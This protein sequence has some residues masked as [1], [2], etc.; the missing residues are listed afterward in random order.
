MFNRQMLYDA[1]IELLAKEGDYKGAFE[2]AE[3]AKSRVLID[4]LAG[5]DIGKTSVESEFIRQDNKYIGEIA[6]GYRKL[7]AA[8][9]GGTLVLKKALDKIEKAEAGHRD[10]ILKIKGQNEELYSLVSVEPLDVTDISQLLDKNTTLFSYYVTDKVLYIWAVNKDRV[11]L[12]RIKI[13]KDETTKLVSAF[14]A[15]ITAKDKKQTDVLSEKIYDNFLKPLIP[16]VKGDRI[17]FIPHGPLYYLP[18]A[19]MSY[20]GQY[21]VD[22]FSIFYLPGAGVLKYV[23]KKQPSAGL[24]VLAFGNPDLGNKQLDLPY[25]EAEVENIKN[26][27][28]QANVYLRTEATKNKV[29]EMLS[30]YSIVH[31]A[32]HG[33]FIEDAPMNSG[34][35][36]A[37]DGQGDGRLT[38]ADIFKLQFKGRA[39]VMSAC[40]TALGLS[41]TGA[42]IMGLNR[43]FL[44]A[45]SPSVVATLWNIEDK[46]TAVFM[47]IFYKNLK[48]NEDIADSLKNTQVEM[49]SRGYE[50]YDWAAFILT[51]KY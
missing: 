42:E 18:F 9:G 16:F 29:K 19:A 43:A 1:L 32:T 27:I 22:G 34:L 4:L 2:T 13:S 3:R 40:K 11:H 25:A 12:E 28:P 41:S 23:M 35:L 36:L 7:S 24:N 38:A 14:T 51:G 21:L 37:A 20:K 26:I 5:K 30:N 6:D 46:S 15:A 45:G 44:Y 8:A 17:G 39:I 47:D 31:F 50:P 49:I 33:L 10:V 48:K